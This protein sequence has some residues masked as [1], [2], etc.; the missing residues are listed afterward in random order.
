[1]RENISE[2]LDISNVSC[3]ICRKD[4]LCVF[5]TDK[6]IVAVRT[7]PTRVLMRE[8]TTLQAINVD[9]TGDIVGV[10]SLKEGGLILHWFQ[11][12]DHS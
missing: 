8:A 11:L 6:E 5:L 3:M 12:S 4:G 1:M 2:W 9:R 7:D 10:E